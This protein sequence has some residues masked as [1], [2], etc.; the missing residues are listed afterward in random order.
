M[1]LTSRE[2][3]EGLTREHFGRQVTACEDVLSLAAELLEADPWRGRPITDSLADKAIAAE[4]A[5]GFKTFRGSFD[6]AIGGF[7]PQAAMLN[8]SLFEGMAVAYWV[9][10]NPD[11]A[12]DM[13]HKHRR[14]ARDKWNRRLV[15]QG[16]PPLDDLP[17]EA[18]MQQLKELFGGEWSTK[19]WCGMSLHELVGAIEPQWDE[20]SELRRFYRIA[21]AD[22]TETDHTTAMSLASPVITDDEVGFRVDSGRSLQYVARGLFAG[23]WSYSHML[24]LA[25]DYFEIDGRERVVPAFERGMGL[26]APLDETEAK[27]VGRNDP[28][29]CGSGVKYKRCH[30]A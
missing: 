24:R 2:E 30:G 20:P 18:E 9:R 5:R 26:I 13:F 15:A 29:P 25:T 7:G 28:C 8:R 21:H 22:H 3:V 17:D 4:A 10:A 6:A 14:L 27:A 23:F 11:E 16:E 1:A 19:L 12:A